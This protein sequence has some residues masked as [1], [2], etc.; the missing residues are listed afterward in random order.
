MVISVFEAPAQVVVL[1]E[2]DTERS[3]ARE[4]SLQTL[5]G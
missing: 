5:V 2:V 1:K 4:K 3:M